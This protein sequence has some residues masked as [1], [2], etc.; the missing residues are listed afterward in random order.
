VPPFPCA[1]V[2]A[3]GGERGLEPESLRRITWQVARGMEYL[4]SH[5]VIHRDI[6]P[7]NLLISRSGIVKVRVR[8]VRLDRYR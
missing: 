5:N 7:E 2:W 4:H 6:K 1:F 3:G 8:R